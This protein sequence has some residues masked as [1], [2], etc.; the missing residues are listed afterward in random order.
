MAD[1]ATHTT[2]PWGDGMSDTGDARALRGRPDWTDLVFFLVLA[3]GAGYAL[4]AY[5]G[6]MDGYEK[7][8]LCLAVPFLTWLGWLWRP[9]RKLMVAVGLAAGLAVWLYQG[10]LARAEQVFL[11]KYL[12]SSQSA[13]FAAIRALTAG[14]AVLSARPTL[15]RSPY[16][17]S[18]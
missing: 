11:L 1:T 14:T 13:I 8:I 18:M 5:P 2:A 10:D 12:F 17:L 3:V 16:T 9:L 4:S 6:A 15:C 7:A